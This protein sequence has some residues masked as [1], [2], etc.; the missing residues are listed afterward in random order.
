MVLFNHAR[1]RLEQRPELADQ[2]RAYVNG[3]IMTLLGAREQ[4]GM[5]NSQYSAK[6]YQIPHTTFV[7]HFSLSFIL[8]VCYHY[9]FPGTGIKMNLFNS[10]F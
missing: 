3:L 5:R 7:L 9:H 10:N 1:T 8:F 2:N 4:A 6:V